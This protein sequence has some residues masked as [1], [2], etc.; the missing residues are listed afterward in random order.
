MSKTQTA[1]KTVESSLAATTVL[2][3]AAGPV[4]EGVLGLANISCPAMIPVAGR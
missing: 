1:D 2:I 4:P 3:P